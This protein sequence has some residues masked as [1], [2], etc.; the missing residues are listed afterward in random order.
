MIAIW[1]SPRPFTMK[2]SSRFFSILIETF[3][4]ASF[5][6]LSQILALVTALPSRPASGE[7]FLQ[8]IMETVGSSTV[9]LGRAFLY[10][11]LQIVSPME[12][13]LTPESTTI[14][15]GS[16]DCTSLKTGPSYACR[17]VTRRFSSPSSFMHTRESF[18]LTEPLMTFPTARRP[19]KSE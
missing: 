14:S 2:V 17:R 4:N 9:I 19:R 3:F 18:V 10:S 12:T 7:M 8:N 1:N 6:S 5:W 11:L 16:T 13:S 15:P